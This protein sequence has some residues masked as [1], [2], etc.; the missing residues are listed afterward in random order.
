MSTRYVVRRLS[1]T[2]DHYNGHTYFS[3]AGSDG[4]HSGVPVRAFPDRAAADACQAALE[5]EARRLLPP[6]RVTVDGH[7][8]HEDAVAW[9]RRVTAL[10]LTPPDLLPSPTD[11]GPGYLDN[12]AVLRWWASHAAAVGPELQETV[13]E[14][15]PIPRFYDVVEVPLVED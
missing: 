3:D 1:W 13:W 7:L 5:A 8:D 4:T 2:P 10:G 6:G 15:M 12:A 11:H 9:C 14:S